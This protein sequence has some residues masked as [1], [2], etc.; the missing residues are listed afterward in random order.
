MLKNLLWIWIIKS[1]QFLY[2][3]DLQDNVIIPSFKVY[4]KFQKKKSPDEDE[5]FNISGYHTIMENA[6]KALC[7]TWNASLS[8]YCCFQRETFKSSEFQQKL[9][10]SPRTSSDLFFF[11]NFQLTHKAVFLNI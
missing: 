6:S 8:L 3:F 11:F 4:K 5:N 10:S 7:T 9:M 2:G 1:A